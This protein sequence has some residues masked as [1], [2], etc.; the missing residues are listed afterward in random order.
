[1]PAS[2]ASGSGRI[3]TSRSLNHGSRG[4]D[5]AVAAAAVLVVAGPV[6]A[7]IGR[8][9]LEDERTGAHGLLGVDIA[10]TVLFDKRLGHV[11]HGAGHDR[12]GQ[13]SVGRRR[14]DAEREIVD[15]AVTGEVP[16]AE[17]P[18]CGAPSIRMIARLAA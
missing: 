7:D 8:V 17:C 14:L 3:F 9:R 18:A 2:C 6:E 16:R 15:D 12:T 11:A 1:M 4:R 13:R 5:E 10:V